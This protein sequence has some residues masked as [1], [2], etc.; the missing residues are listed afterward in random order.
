[1]AEQQAA[2]ERQKLELQKSASEQR[3]NNEQLAAQLREAQQKLE[4]DQ[5]TIAA[6]QQA[7]NEKPLPTAIATLFL[8]PASRSSDNE[9]KLP[10]GSSGIRLQLAVDSVDYKSFVVQ[11]KN[12]Q[13]KIIF[14]PKVR[15]PSSG[16]VI[17]VTVGG[18]V[19]PAGAY[20]V[21]LS[22]ISPEGT[23]LVANYSFRITP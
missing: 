9:K 14:Q 21:Q 19:L 2:L 6:L 4:A 5:Q 10:A 8:L 22:G 11:L 18:K 20:S 16:R 23:E 7:Q 3:L 15:A 13:D 12:S 1:L 17:T